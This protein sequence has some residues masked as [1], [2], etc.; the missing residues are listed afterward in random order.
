MD[1]DGSDGRR[2]S[3]RPEGEVWRKP[4]DMW[5]SEGRARDGG[6]RTCN[7]VTE[8]IMD[9]SDGGREMVGRLRPRPG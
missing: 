3:C 9:E 7:L 4:T 5:M 6:P 8:A 1:V 2:N